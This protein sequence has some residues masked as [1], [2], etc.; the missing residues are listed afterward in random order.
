VLFGDTPSEA[1]ARRRVHH[2]GVPATLFVEEGLD[3]SLRDGLVARGHAIEEI[4]HSAVVQMIRIV[5]EDGR[6]RL[7][8]SSDPRKGGRPAGR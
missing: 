4:E 1:L 8:A 7:L 2:Q 3:P 5:R 6:V